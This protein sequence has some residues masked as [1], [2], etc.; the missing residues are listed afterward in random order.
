MPH[1]DGEVEPCAPG[2]PRPT[3]LGKRR[4]VAQPQPLVGSAEVPHSEE[5][6]GAGCA[7]LV[8]VLDCKA[9]QEL[10]Y[11][12]FHLRGDVRLVHCCEV[13]TAQEGMH[14]EVSHV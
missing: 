7:V 13:Y 10:V 14:G 11:P 2:R 6:G 8:P 4:P 5:G 9:A 1:L 3:A 12:H